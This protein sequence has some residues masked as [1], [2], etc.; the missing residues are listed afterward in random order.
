[1]NGV[2]GIDFNPICN[3][4]P[5]EVRRAGIRRHLEQQRYQRELR[6]EREAAKKD[7]SGSDK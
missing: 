3:Q 7:D 5:K 4:L 1:M 2:I 6:A